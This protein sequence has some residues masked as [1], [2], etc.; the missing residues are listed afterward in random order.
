M[1]LWCSP[2]ANISNPVTKSPNRTLA[3]LDGGKLDLDVAMLRLCR[4][5][6]LACTLAKSP[7]VGHFVYPS[8]TSGAVDN[9]YEVSHFLETPFAVTNIKRSKTR[10][11]VCEYSHSQRRFDSE[12][13]LYEA[14]RIKIDCRELELRGRQQEQFVSTMTMHT[15]WIVG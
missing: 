4:D 14:V 15:N 6:L 10:P 8:C 3:S 11:G 2:T 12:S 5:K 7:A 1:T 13:I 9:I